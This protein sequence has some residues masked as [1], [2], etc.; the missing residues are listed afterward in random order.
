MFLTLSNA[1]RDFSIVVADSGTG[2]R[3]KDLA[4]LFEPLWQSDRP[5]AEGGLGLGLA[6]VREI[7]E[8][9]GG[10]IRAESP[11]EGKGATF[12]VQMPWSTPSAA[13]TQ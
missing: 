6:I 1:E 5:A 13:A 3:E 9:H 12:I 11:G 10:S 2:I 7:V 8:L 4:H